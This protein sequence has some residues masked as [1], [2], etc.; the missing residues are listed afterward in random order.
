MTSVGANSLVALARPS[1][2]V[3]TRCSAPA[4]VTPSA[5]AALVVCPH[6]RAPLA[7]ANWTAS[8]PTPPLAPSTST[9]SSGPL[10]PRVC[11]QFQAVSPATP[12]AAAIA[13]SWSSRS[14]TRALS[15]TAAFVA[16]SPCRITPTPP[17]RIRTGRPSTIPAPSLPGIHG[18]FAAALPGAPR[19]IQM[20]SGFTDAW[21][22]STTTSPSAG[23]GSGS[24]PNCS[25]PPISVRYEAR[26]PPR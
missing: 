17:P 15:G 20:S 25:G 6:T 18:R 24:S 19:V 3:T 8:E 22:T 7:T 16:K 26:M 14:S 13:G 9:R 5:L 12:S 11:T 21:V 10:R 1:A 2:S 23:V 4:A